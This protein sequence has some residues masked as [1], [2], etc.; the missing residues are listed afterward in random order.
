MLCNLHYSCL[1]NGSASPVSLILKLHMDNDEEDSDKYEFNEF[2][3]LN[4]SSL[5]CCLQY[6]E[7]MGYVVNFRCP[8]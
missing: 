5:T 3:L 8:T 4:I 1:L 6:S 7:I 2:Y